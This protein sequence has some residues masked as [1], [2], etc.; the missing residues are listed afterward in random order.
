MAHLKA[1]GDRWRVQLGRNRPRPGVGVVLFFCESTS[2]R[3]YR[4][5]EV[6][7]ERFASQEDID[8]LGTAQLMELYRQ[9]YSL[10]FPKLRSDERTD[11]RKD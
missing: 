3:P 10:D 5:V 6:T 4:V 1:D 11:V 9:S 7:D 2:Q 8:R